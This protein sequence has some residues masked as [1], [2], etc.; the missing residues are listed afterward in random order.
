ME[1]NGRSIEGDVFKLKHLVTR[2]ERLAALFFGDV[3]PECGDK[4]VCPDHGE[5]VI[6]GSQL[7]G[8]RTMYFLMPEADN[9]SS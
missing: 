4:V 6:F 8:S 7:V 3:S 5:L 2:E 1:L 9:A